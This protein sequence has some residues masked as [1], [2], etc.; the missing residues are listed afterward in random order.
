MALTAEEAKLSAAS[1]TPA[2]ITLSIFILRGAEI[3]RA[4]K[5]SRQTV[6]NRLVLKW[7]LAVRRLLARCR[8]PP[9]HHH[10]QPDRWHADR[11]HRHREGDGTV[12]TTE[13]GRGGACLINPIDL[14]VRATGPR[15]PGRC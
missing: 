4:P 10:D 12:A 9:R 15:R 14:H 6:R 13:G 1:M 8:M 5:G 2:S 11:H 7:P 3:D